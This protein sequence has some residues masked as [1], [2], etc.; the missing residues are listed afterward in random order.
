MPGSKGS[1]M[2]C[3]LAM[4][5]IQRSDLMDMARLYQNRP[6]PSAPPHTCWLRLLFLLPFLDDLETGVVPLPSPDVA[7]ECA[8]SRG[9]AAGLALF[10]MG[11]FAVL[12]EPP[13]FVLAARYG[14]QRFM[15]GAL[16]V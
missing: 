16:L 8:R 11:A 15:R 5:R 10:A 14:R 9:T 4:R 7:P 12:V 13:L 3:S 6:M 2:L 1:I